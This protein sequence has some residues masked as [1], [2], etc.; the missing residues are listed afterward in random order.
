MIFSQKLFILLL[1][2]SL[3]VGCETNSMWPSL[4]GEAP[5]KTSERTKINIAAPS[6]PAP[7]G[8]LGQSYRP[9][10]LTT[11][12]QR[13]KNTRN[14]AGNFQNSA[15]DKSTGTFVGKKIFS[16]R[17]DLS[18]LKGAIDRLNS[19][20]AKIRGEN[21]AATQRYHGIVAAMSAKLQAGTTPGNPVLVKQWNEAQ[22]QL[23][24]IEGNISKMN[25][26]SNDSGS[27]A[28][29]A[30]YLLDSVRATYTLSGAV[31]ED[32]VQLRSLEDEVNRTVI[33][34]DRLLNELSNDINRQTG[35]LGNE[36]RNLTTMSIAIKNGERYGASLVNRAFAQTEIKTRA[37]VRSGKRRANSRPLVVIRFDRPNVA[38]QQALYNAVSRAVERKP[39]AAFDLVAVSPKAGS[40]SARILN[41]T[42][43]KRN[44][45]GVLRTLTDMGLPAS[46]VNLT[47]TNS[48]SARSNEV[49]VYVR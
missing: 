36:R 20:M 29:V 34:I 40:P 7:V 9:P 26:L 23:E 15:G 42:A 19:R 14:V 8:S 22:Q 24:K 13:E 25:G 4:T 16:M 27:E 30:G 6:A 10:Q 21:E 43:A 41:T 3:I 35:Y 12:P 2:G 28:T 38:Y 48:T 18:K 31:D 44:A 45:E 17:G 5:R 47:A 32:H 1:S 37:V 46:R 33:F 11:Q 39:E 49:R